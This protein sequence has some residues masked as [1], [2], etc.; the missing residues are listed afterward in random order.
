MPTFKSHA[1]RRSIWRRGVVACN[2]SGL[3]KASY[4]RKHQ[5]TYHQLIY[6]T[7]QLDAQP[8]VACINAK[9]PGIESDRASRFLP[10]VFPQRAI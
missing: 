8:T 1:K 10:E 5:L 9:P 4:C 7:A 3:S 2:D 6:W